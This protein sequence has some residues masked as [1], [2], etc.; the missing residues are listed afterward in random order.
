MCS[1]FSF[2]HS[3]VCLCYDSHISSLSLSL[4]I[5]FSH[6]LS[7]STSHH[8][9][10]HIF[11]FLKQTSFSLSLC[12]SFCFFF[13]VFQS[14]T[15]HFLRPVI[16]TA[17]FSRSDVLMSFLDSVSSA[18]MYACVFRGRYGAVPWRCLPTSRQSTC[19][20]QKGGERER[21]TGS[22]CVQMSFLPPFPPSVSPLFSLGLHCLFCYCC[23]TSSQSPII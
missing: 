8:L 9:F 4:C 11:S 1:V 5:M 7:T 2:S 15:R 21:N 23:L 12:L 10:H 17:V 16:V 13:S 19:E 6:A 22:H 3:E 18:L 20:R 14:L